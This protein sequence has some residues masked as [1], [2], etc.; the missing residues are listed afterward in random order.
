MIRLSAWLAVGFSLLYAVAE[1]LHNWGDWQWT[2]FWL[3]DYIC[4][5]L[6]SYG[7]WICL[8][9]DEVR[10]LSGAWGA[11]ASVFY[12][13][14]FTHIQALRS[15]EIAHQGLVSSG[16]AATMIGFMLVIVI[17]GF[18]MSLLGK[19]EKGSS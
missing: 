8:K 6:L 7:A 5:G 9:T 14:F 4:I 12:W 11:T 15:D 2:P 19:R 17:V 3:I 16:F 18:V 10:W 13:S 1:V